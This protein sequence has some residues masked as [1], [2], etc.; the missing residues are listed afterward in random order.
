[1][2]YNLDHF[3]LLMHRPELLHH[4]Y[5]AYCIQ[6]TWKQAAAT[7][8]LE[9]IPLRARPSSASSLTL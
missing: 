3:I 9:R 7:P 1:M 4:T 5:N 8:A 2:Y 6:G